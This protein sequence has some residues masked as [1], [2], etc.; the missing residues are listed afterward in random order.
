MTEGFVFD[1]DG[2]LFDGR[3]ASMEALGITTEHFRSRFN[4]A[5]GLVHGLP[6]LRPRALISLVYSALSLSPAKLHEIEKFYRAELEKAEDKIALRPEIKQLLQKLKASGGKLAVLSSRRRKDLQRRLC[7]IAL[8]RLIDV[9]HGRDSLPNPKP[10]PDALTQIAQELDLKTDALV[11]IGDSKEDYQCAHDANVPYYH[12]T[13]SGQ[14]SYG[15]LDQAAATFKTPSDLLEA[16]STR[17]SS[18]LLWDHSSLPNELKDAIE[19]RDLCFYAGSGISVPSG[20]GDWQGH[21]RGV[22]Q[23][24]GAGYLIEE[25]MDLPELLQLL[26]AQAEQTK[27]VFDRFRKS[28]DRPEVEPNTYHYAMLRAQPERIW[29]SN[30]DQL[31]E[32]A[33]DIG[34]FGYQIVT[35][36]RGLLE[37]FR[38]ARLVVKMN[39]DFATA[40]YADDLRWDL[41]FTQEQFDLVERQRPEIWRL[42]EDDYRNRCILFVGVSFRDAALHRILAVARQKIPRTRY[43]HYLLTLR[44][45]D[46]VQSRKEELQAGNLQRQYIKTLFFSEFASIDSFVAE[47]AIARRRPIIGFSGGFGRLK[48]EASAKEIKTFLSRKLDRGSMTGARVKEFGEHLGEALAEAG[49]RVT[50]GCSPVV[51]IPPV[52][53]A[54]HVA[55]TQARFYLRTRGG[56]NYDS[57]APAIVV[58]PDT[59]RGQNVYAAMRQCYI[60]E[61]S[62]LIAY[63]S[64]ARPDG[65]K[66]GTIEEIEMAMAKHIPVL[67]IPQVGGEACVYRETFMQAIDRS[68]PDAALAREIRELNQKIS[69]VSP[70][71]FVEF[72]R[73]DLAEGIH[74]L[75]REVMRSSL[76][77]GNREAKSTDW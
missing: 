71:K 12:I 40:T 52:S 24:L 32:K 33:N 6:L 54:F 9:Y 31:F 62:L 76:Q 16:L 58:P 26:A 20:I 39:G 67:I 46:P 37:H 7:Q 2:P 68:Y 57:T 61:L 10:H 29:T 23:E 69:K 11:F 14:S 25:G 53:G 42:F 3:K 70:E 36:D 18:V 45:S 19:K 74:M 44:S 27:L 50:S 1:F 21:Y 56:T 22:L 5:V 75:M 64:P 8:E 4:T 51:G 60:S 49:F 63:G 77:V 47:T 17:T 59:R 15:E 72:A 38:S 55:P 13:W 73:G 43:S 48:K 34:G 30:Y 41:I 65:R 28:F 66:S 35:N